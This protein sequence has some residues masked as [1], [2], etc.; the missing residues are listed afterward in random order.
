MTGNISDLEPCWSVHE[1][2]KP[3]RRH[4]TCQPQIRTIKF[5]CQELCFLV[6]KP[7]QCPRDD[8]KLFCSGVELS[9][10]NRLLKKAPYIYFK[11]T[12]LAGLQRL[13]GERRKF[14]WAIQF[15]SEVIKL[16][17]FQVLG[18]YSDK[19]K[20]YSWWNWRKLNSGNVC[21]I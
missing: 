16:D 8:L 6:Q 11:T 4:H 20:R 12:E 15:Y 5:S 19:S 2:V 1:A 14:Q 17:N 10:T 18:T 9:S 3:Q 21:S 7:R 13:K